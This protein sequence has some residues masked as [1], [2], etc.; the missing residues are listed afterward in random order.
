MNGLNGRK[1]TFVRFL[2]SHI[3]MNKSKKWGSFVCAIKVS[4]TV[5]SQTKYPLFVYFAVCFVDL[6]QPRVNFQQHIRYKKELCVTISPFQ[7]QGGYA[8]YTHTNGANILRKTYPLFSSQTPTHPSPIS[9][10]NACPVTHEVLYLPTHSTLLYFSLHPL[11][12]FI[13]TA[14]KSHLPFRIR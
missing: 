7:P 10:H 5:V 4:S 9:L 14:K 2:L 12:F 6:I 11:F 13:N 8:P 3:G 1:S